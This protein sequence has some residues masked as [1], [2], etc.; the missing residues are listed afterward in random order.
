MMRKRDFKT[1]TSLVADVFKTF[2]G[3]TL[4][5]NND[6]IKNC[7]FG[8]QNWLKNINLRRCQLADCILHSGLNFANLKYPDN[9]GVEMCFEAHTNY[10]KSTPPNLPKY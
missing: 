9:P 8:Q 4:M 3:M 1:K 7:G 5:Q 10:K 2:K 6:L